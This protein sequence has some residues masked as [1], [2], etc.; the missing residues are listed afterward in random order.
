MEEFN[1]IGAKVR[2]D[3][4]GSSLSSEPLGLFAVYAVIEAFVVEE[5]F[6]RVG[7][8]VF[9]EVGW[10]CDDVL[11]DIKD[12]FGN[13]GGVFEVSG[14]DGDIKAFFDHV[15]V[16]CGGEDFEGHVGVGTEKLE[17]HLGER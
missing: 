5:I 9:L 15:D 13:E 12:F 6:G 4:D 17:K 14:A 8:S 16:A 2:S 11:L 10:T 7:C 1:V 3:G